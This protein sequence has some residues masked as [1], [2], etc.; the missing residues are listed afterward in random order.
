MYMNEQL[1]IDFLKTKEILWVGINF[2]KA[3]FTRN[4][5]TLTQESMQ[6]L[7]HEFERPE[8]I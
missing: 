7:F 8:K 6:H 4:G 5:F 1:F 2:S 3:K